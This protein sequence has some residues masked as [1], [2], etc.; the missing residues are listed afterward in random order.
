MIL[1]EYFF[2]RKVKK[3]IDNAR[4]GKHKFC[5]LDDAGSMLILYQYEDK[6]AVEPLLEKLR[7]TKKRIFCCISHSGT[8]E[9][10]NPSMIYVNRNKDA[11]KYGIPNADISAQLAKVQADVLIDLSRGKCHTLKVLMLQHPSL[12]KVGERLLDDSVYDFSIIM[13]D[14]GGTADLF[15]YILF[16]L[17]TIRSK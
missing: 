9:N 1:G 5:S 12:F 16:Y 2:K 10:D 13:T 17:Q 3:L 4:S 6:E 14:G 8:I 7:S 11:D 15:G